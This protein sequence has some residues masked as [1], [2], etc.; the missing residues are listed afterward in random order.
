MLLCSLIVLLLGLGFFF[1]VIPQSMRASLVSMPTA[2][3]AALASLVENIHV[4]SSDQLAATPFGG[5]R[6]RVQASRLISSF[7]GDTML[8][9]DLFSALQSASNL[10]EQNGPVRIGTAS[11]AGMLDVESSTASYSNPN[12]L[13]G[14]DST[15]NSRFYQ[16]A[17][18]VDL[19]IINAGGGGTFFGNYS[20]TNSTIVRSTGALQVNST[21][22]SFFTGTGNVGM[23]FTAPVFIAPIVS[24]AAATQAAFPNFSWPSKR[25]QNQPRSGAMT[26]AARDFGYLFCAT[27]D[28]KAA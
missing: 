24:I 11:P 7:R 23:G 17:S 13:I 26:A 2:A 18:G 15:H 22:N 4:I 19:A 9:P 27:S 25:N 14:Y 5:M 8:S 16:A 3:C 10:L 1:T 12:L 6:F 21:G 28:L 20:G